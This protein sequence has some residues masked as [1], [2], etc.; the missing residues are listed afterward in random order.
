MS[1]PFVGEIRLFSFPRIP[2]GWLSCDGTLLPI[3]QYDAL[4]SLLGTLYGGDGQT[5][6][7]LPDLRGRLPIGY[8]NGN[9]LTP[10]PIGQKSGSET[11]TLLS[12]QI[13]QHSHSFHAT[14]AAASSD[15]PSPSVQL[16]TPS[17]SDTMYATDITGLS[18]YP[19]QTFAIS[20]SGGN[21]PHD[22]CMPTL[23][24]SYCIAYVGIYPSRS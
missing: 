16:G 22:N 15:T 20:P 3:S 17:N 11:V 2:R 24:A 19:L 14:S 13:P 23:T 8:G 18:P 6:F 4:F 1:E 5:T 7:G 9:G 10:R 12:T 21:Q